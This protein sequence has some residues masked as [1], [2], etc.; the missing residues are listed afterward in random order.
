MRRIGFGK[1]SDWDD[2]L[3]SRLILLL[4]E[5]Q[6]GKTHECHA[7][8]K[9]L[10]EAGEP[11]FYIELS[12]VAA[13][14]WR[15]WRSPSETE[16]FQRWRR[17]ETEV[18]TFFL[19]SVDELRLT[20]GKFR[21]ALRN[22][23]NDLDGHMAR[24]RVVLTSRPLP[25]DRKLFLQIFEAPKSPAQLTENDFADL[26]MGRARE[27][28]KDG[29]PEVRYV[30]L[31][32]LG[33]EDVAK[34]AAS[35]GVHDT[36][37][38]LKSLQASS[39]MEFMRRPQDVIEAASAWNE[40]SGRFGTHA[41]Q[42]EFDIKARL[43]PNPT[44]GDGQ[45]EDNRALEGAKRLA[46][47]VVLTQ[48]LTIRHDVNNDLGDASTVVDP[49]LILDDWH[50]DDRKALLERGLFGF[51][52]YGRVR[53][54]NRL[55]FEF[56][57]AWRLAD[58][59]GAGMSRKAV[60]RLLVVQTAQAF[61]VIRPSLRE[62]AA[63][64]VLWQPWVFELANN[65][66]PA[67]LMSLGDP[68]SLSVEQRRKLLITYIERFGMGGRRGLSVP[69]IQIHRLA[70]AALGPIVKDKFGIIENLEVRRVLLQ[71]IG[72]A[73]LHD[74][75]EIA[76]WVIRDPKVDH[77]ERI[78]ALAALI[79][80]DDPE[81]ARI[82]D[83]LYDLPGQWDQRFAR[84]VICHLFPQHMS[85]DQLIGVLGWVQ[86]AR[87]TGAELSR[88]LPMRIEGLT[89]ERLEEL[90]RGLTSLVEE[91][92]AFD[93]NT[94]RPKNKHSHLIHLLA[95]TCAL[96]SEGQA[97][98]PAHA[99][100]VVLAA[101][102]AR[103]IGSNNTLPSKLSKAIASASTTIRAAIFEEDVAL[104]RKLRPDKPR[105]DLFFELAHRGTLN[106]RPNDTV[107]MRVLLADKN[108]SADLRAAALLMEVFGFAWGREDREAYLVGLRS[109]GADDQELAAFLEYQL[110]P[111]IRT[112]QERQW[113][114]CHR[115]RERQFERRKEKDRA[116]WVMFWR[117][118]KDDPV[119]AF[120]PERAENTAWNLWRVMEHGG[121]RSR[122]SG[123]DRQLIEEHLG[124]E[125][126]DRL[127]AALMPLWRREKPPLSS[128]RPEDERNT[129]FTTWSLAL[130][131][132]TAEAEDPE[133]AIRLCRGEAETAVR[134]SS[135]NSSGFPAWLGALTAAHPEIVEN[136][137]G[138]EVGWTLSS[139]AKANSRSI[140]LQDVQHA[141]PEVA[142]LFLPRF[143]SW[144]QSTEGVPGEADDVD[145]A[146]DRLEQVIEILIKFGD[147][148]D[149]E[150]IGKTA[151]IALAQG[152]IKPFMRVLLPALFAVDPEKAVARLEA[153]CSDVE[154]S[155]E[156][157]AVAWF[158]RLFGGLHRGRGV[159]LRH[160]GMTPGLLLRLLRLAYQH[161]ERD[162]DAVHE[163]SYSPDMRDDAEHGRG[164]LLNAVVELSGP[165]GWRAKLEIASDPEFSHL[166][167][168]LHA[169]A[170]E[171]SAR[172]SDNLAM[173]PQ[174]VV[175]LEL[176][177]E[178]GPRSSAEMFALMMD[179][180]ADLCDYLLSDS[181][182]REMWASVRD[183]RVMRRAI[184]EQLEAHA[185]AAYSVAQENV[186]ADEKET[187]IRLRSP[188]NAVEGV[189]EL[190][191]G[192][193]GYSGAELR[194][195][196]SEQLVGKYL[197]PANRRAGCLV[198]TRAERDGWH[199][200][201]TGKHLDFAGLIAMLRESAQALQ[202]S[203]PD[204][205]HIDVVGLDLK[206]RLT[207]E[208]EARQRADNL[209][210]RRGGNPW[211]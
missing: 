87:S 145:G 53:F 8:Q 26:A 170:E 7:R 111:H 203:F 102:L 5:A 172:E 191:I 49:V 21:T 45:L 113:E 59:I 28:K 179:R 186:T 135:M 98:S 201:D 188:I 106:L 9:A 153:V 41:K 47:A 13:Q 16:R 165:E 147:E 78:D 70:D 178:P 55:A 122:S 1:T 124:K 103:G 88:L 173:R 192:D 128:E 36:D 195:F 114:V 30:S 196:V 23:A 139:P 107:W 109:F 154:V 142:R 185:R 133:W 158:A 171:K 210:V 119:T 27:E 48:R 169:L 121:A 54:H 116:S 66:D 131:A 50:D 166:R 52:S 202:I 15:D 51:A 176:R 200:P 206:R 14:P 144:L 155:R 157:T 92:L 22:V 136:V 38:F 42:V 79:A 143:R 69:R 62:V 168:R 75:A 83:E 146:A 132:I 156:S 162:E 175:K 209:Q 43:R 104:T 12:S 93:A 73:R 29:P 177:T 39:M 99:G 130:A 183:E 80:L 211:S 125:I 18:A 167:D 60:R 182:P 151:S 148:T 34:L 97:L 44:R 140:L 160:P 10:W 138:N 76:K 180:L 17:T 6:S 141:S 61:D 163:G 118:L 181:S 35:R 115:W 189:I 58:L 19:D 64:L 24:V 63:W 67:L 161:V 11:A 129:Y 33:A 112:R 199:H 100:S 95:K 71:L 57:A 31:L 81:L 117:E 137:L 105:L 85:V 37:A 174:E 65:L 184:T 89:V 4:S 123:W 68:G 204:E 101:A 77:Y 94:H 32:P 134:Y 46:L 3:K 20:Q 164:M 197:A 40:L 198:I 91:G 150:A 110:K 187:D 152:S 194:T 193:K 90:R 205:I 72:H 149:R 74:C 86:E 190:K 82:A 2:V 84:S 208:R 120:G 56:L 127:R 96:L 207:T 159:E 126:A 108:K 25:V